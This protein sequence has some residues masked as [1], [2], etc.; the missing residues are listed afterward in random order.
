MSFVRRA[1]SPFALST[2]GCVSLLL[3][4]TRLLIDDE[5]QDKPTSFETS[6]TIAEPVGSGVVGKSAEREDLAISFTK[7]RSAGANPRQVS[8][9]DGDLRATAAML[10]RDGDNSEVGHAIACMLRSN[11]EFRSKCEGTQLAAVA[12]AVKADYSS[13]NFAGR[14]HEWGEQLGGLGLEFALY[15][16]ADAGVPLAT[17]HRFLNGFDRPACIV[18]PSAIPA[19]TQLFQRIS[20]VPG[21]RDSTNLPMQREYEAW[22]SITAAMAESALVFPAFAIRRDH[23]LEFRELTSLPPDA[24]AVLASHRHS[25]EFPSL[26]VLSVEAA[27]ALSPHEG[28]NSRTGLG[29]D[30]LLSLGIVEL[31]PA[32]ASQLAKRRAGVLSVGLSGDPLKTL[33]DEAAAELAGL[34]GGR[35]EL[36]VRD[37]SMKAQDALATCRGGVS[38]R[39]G[40]LVLSSSRLV[41]KICRESVGGTLLLD[42]NALTNSAAEA[43]R[44]YGNGVTLMFTEPLRISEPVAKVL[45]AYDGEIQFHKLI[46]ET[47]EVLAVLRAASP[48]GQEPAATQTHFNGLASASTTSSTTSDASMA[49]RESEQPGRRNE[50]I[51]AISPTFSGLLDFPFGISEQAVAARC[52]VE[53]ANVEDQDGTFE[54][55]GLK[56]LV[57]M[58][59]PVTETDNLPVEFVLRDDSLIGMRVLIGYVTPDAF[60]GFVSSLATRLG[61]GQPEGSADDYRDAAVRFS[62]GKPHAPL[63]VAFNRRRTLVG[64]TWNEK[65]RKSVSEVI[66]RENWQPWDLTQDKLRVPESQ[67]PQSNNVVNSVGIEL[68][69]IPA[70]TYVTGSPETEKERLTTETPVRVTLT[71]DFLIGKTEVTRRQWEQVMGTKPWEE[72]G[73]QLDGDFP[74]ERISAYDAEKFCEELTQRELRSGGLR[75]NESYRLPTTAEWEY[76]CRAGAETAF[77]FGEDALKLGDFGWFDGNANGTAHPVGSKQPNSWGLYDMHGNVC[78]WCSDGTGDYPSDKVT[79]PIAPFLRDIQACRGGCWRYEAEDCRSA[80][81]SGKIPSI[82]GN[83]F[84]FRVVRSSSVR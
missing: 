64:L 20:P 54:G 23:D 81:Q 44:D 27:A 82:R 83:G 48:S 25:I 26:R 73:N 17:L 56:S 7:P 31:T 39:R 71:R 68:I 16:H 52:P 61:K 78:E 57:A 12:S 46:P 14:Q 32:V 76:A 72:L 19:A 63:R 45:A 15:L 18:V 60:G 38:L 50:V 51:E 35:L 37:V 30:N 13:Y 75:A 33:S 65:Q 74:A 47:A 24:A 55:S 62:E 43:F 58:H 22:E 29:S 5:Q 9:S 53:L 42:C 66:F 1:V 49:G 36:G 3:L 59:F 28:G 80:R 40:P 69:H 79:D 84:G 8:P 2:V 11:H 41:Q 6:S 70:G 67:K 77:S 21:G 10:E 34:G 4:A